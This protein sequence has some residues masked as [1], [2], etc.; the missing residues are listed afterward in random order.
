M[1]QRRKKHMAR[2]GLEPRSSP[3]P[4]EHSS[5][6]IDPWQFS[7]WLN[8]YVPESARNRAG[9]NETRLTLCCSQSG[10]G[11][12]LSH[13]MSWGG[14]GVQGPTVDSNRGLL[15]YRASTP[16]ILFIPTKSCFIIQDV[17]VTVQE[18]RGTQISLTK[19]ACICSPNYIKRNVSLGLKPLTID[20]S[21]YYDFMENMVSDK[22]M[23]ALRNRIPKY[24]Y[25]HLWLW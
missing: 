11:P 25:N 18:P 15:T 7:P 12:T 1:S 5:L 23:S 21:R 17:L 8:G 16:C 4:C 9:T 22:I 19:K 6:T 14:G 20:F 13:Q 10:H 2:P 24:T 3:L